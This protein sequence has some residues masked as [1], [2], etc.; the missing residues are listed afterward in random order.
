MFFRNV[1]STKQQ[2]DL[3]WYDLFLIFFL[4]RKHLNQIDASPPVLRR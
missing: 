4:L 2:T 1:M 3:S